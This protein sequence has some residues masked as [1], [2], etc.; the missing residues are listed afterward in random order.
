LSVGYELFEGNKAEVGTLSAAIESWKELFKIDSVCFVGD[1][2]ITVR[3]I[4]SKKLSMTT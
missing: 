4:L 2:D 3:P 1:I